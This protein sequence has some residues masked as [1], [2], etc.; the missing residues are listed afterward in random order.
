M[1][2]PNDPRIDAMLTQVRDTQRRMAQRAAIAAV[3]FVTLGVMAI[4]LGVIRYSGEAGGV[5]RAQFAG[6]RIVLVGA[7]LIV[8]GALA[9]FGAW[10]NRR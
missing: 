5:T 1:T 2:E 10:L 7:G 8:V 9:G 6:T 3:V 4:V